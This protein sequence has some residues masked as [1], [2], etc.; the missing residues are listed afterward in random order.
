MANN[1]RTL[2]VQLFTIPKLVDKD[3][4]GTLELLRE[5]GYQ[6]VEF[7]GPY[8]FSAEA[9]KK[10]WAGF[11][12]M[13][14]LENDAFYGFTV[15]ETAQLLKDNELTAPSM[16]TDLRTLRDGL[17][18]MLDEVAKLQPKY[19]VL[20][21]INEGRN[22]LDD[23]KK[24]AEE[25]NQF[26]EQMAKYDMQFV[27][28]NHGYEH[29]EMDDEIPMHFLLKNTNPDYVQ[30]EL[31]IFWMQAAGA[32]PIEFLKNYPN[33]YKLLHIKDASEPFRFSGDGSTPDQWMAGFPKMADPGDGVFD[34]KGI[35]E[36][37]I[38]AGVDHFLLERDLAPDPEGTLRN[39]Y[40]N[41]RSMD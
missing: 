37:A 38:A 12:G 22:S 28:H 35:I 14:G 11:K 13:L 41:L 32:N 9:T 18:K 30:F 20:P 16:H 8:P 21:A 3:F 27:Y 24:L 34:I 29:I 19:L 26:G 6:E 7:F 40:A 15:A 25:F 1:N 33:Q 36:A 10:E 4:K 39:S 2:G 5:I 31:D 17:E 23:Y